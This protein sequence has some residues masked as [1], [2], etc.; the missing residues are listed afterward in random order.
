MQVKLDIKVNQYI[1]DDLKATVDIYCKAYT[2]DPN[3]DPKVFMIQKLPKNALG[4]LD[5]R[6]SHV[7]DPVDMQDWPDHVSQDY[8]YFRTDQIKLRV[9][10]PFIAQRVIQQLKNGVERLIKAKN[11]LEAYQSSDSPQPQPEYIY[12]GY[13][14]NEDISRHAQAHPELI[15]KFYAAITPQMILQAEAAGTMQKVEAS[16]LKS[17]TDDQPFTRTL[18]IPKFGWLLVTLPIKS[19]YKVVK[20]GFPGAGVAGGV[21]FAQD[22][23]GANGVQNT[24]AKLYGQVN[25]N[26]SSLYTTF[27]IKA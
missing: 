26:Q 5:M 20:Q 3:S 14:S 2:E 19:I 23:P 27:I 8:A 6:F 18:Q 12:F 17:Y 9:R 1:K 16:I 7:A 15:T 10:S 11:F 24:A 4:Q 22:N 13:I 21:P 25:Q